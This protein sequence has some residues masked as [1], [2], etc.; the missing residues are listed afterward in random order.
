MAEI[1]DM[2]NWVYLQKSV[3][4][5]YSCLEKVRMINLIYGI[6][7]IPSEDNKQTTVPLELIEFSMN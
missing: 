4:G 6:K 3:E 5:L 1:K 2:E 7:L